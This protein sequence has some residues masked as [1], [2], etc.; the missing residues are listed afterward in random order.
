MM[1]SWLVCWLH[2]NQV[3]SGRHGVTGDYYKCREV[4]GYIHPFMDCE[5]QLH[6]A[7]ST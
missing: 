6:D 7:A 3:D 1:L 4:P 2:F 5:A